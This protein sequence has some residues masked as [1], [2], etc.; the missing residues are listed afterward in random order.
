[1]GEAGT[2]AAQDVTGQV[3]SRALNPQVQYE[4]WQTLDAA[5]MGA[6]GGGGAYITLQA[7]PTKALDLIR[8]GQK[9][10]GNTTA[11]LRRVFPGAR[12]APDQVAAGKLIE[13]D[14]DL[15][16]FNEDPVQFGENLG[17][18]AADRARWAGAMI[19]KMVADKTIPSRIK[20]GLADLRGRLDDPEAQARVGS[21]WSAANAGRV[22]ARAV[23]AFEKAWG[24][25]K[26]V[27][28]GVAQGVKKSELGPEARFQEIL[29]IMNAGLR[30]DYQD[31]PQVLGLVRTVARRLS[32]TEGELTDSQLKA[33]GV[34]GRMFDDP[35][36]TYNQLLGAIGSENL[37]EKVTRA[38]PAEHDARIANSVLR[39][40]L[41]EEA[42]DY[43]D[44]DP[45]AAVQ[46]GQLIDRIVSRG[47]GR[48]GDWPAAIATLANLYGSE[49]AL[50]DVLSYYRE[51]RG[52]DP[53]RTEAIVD[54]EGE[55]LELDED[56]GGE[57]D[58]GDRLTE[59]ETESDVGY[60]FKQSGTQNEPFG[61]R[62]E[63]ARAREQ[64]GRGD[65]IT[66]L[67][68]AQEQGDDLEAAAQYVRERHA[69]RL[70]DRREQGAV[71]EM[72]KRWSAFARETDPEKKAA[73]KKRW[74]YSKALLEPK[75]MTRTE[76]MAGRQAVLEK[77]SA[78]EVLKQFF[79]V[80][81]T[82]IQRNEFDVSDRDLAKM[83]VLAKQSYKDKK[84]NDERKRTLFDLVT[85]DGRKIK[86]S[87]ESVWKTWAE[88][89][90]RADE[91]RFTQEGARVE[92]PKPFMA[93]MFMEALVGLRM[94]EDVEAVNWDDDLL[95]DRD[96]GLTWGE[97][98]ITGLQNPEVKEFEQRMH[99]RAW[100]IQS[101][102][103]AAVTPDISG[104]LEEGF[105]VRKWRRRADPT[106]G[107]PTMIDDD[108]RKFGPVWRKKDTG[109]VSIDEER[110]KLETRLAEEEGIIKPSDVREIE[111]QRKD[112]QFPP[113]VYKF[114]EEFD[115]ILSRAGIDLAEINRLRTEA[116]KAAARLVGNIAR[117][118]GVPTEQVLGHAYGGENTT[119]ALGRLVITLAA[120]EIFHKRGLDPMRTAMHEVGHVIV[121]AVA[122]I[123][124]M[125]VAAQM[126]NLA[127]TPRV[128][129]QVLASR[130]KRGLGTMYVA[131]SPEELF[132]E[133]FAAYMG[134][135]LQLKTKNPLLRVFEYIKELLGRVGQEEETL[136]A[137]FE[138]V[139]RGE[140]N[141]LNLSPKQTG[142]T[143]TR[144]QVGRFVVYGLPHIGAATL[145]HLEHVLRNR[146]P[147]LKG[148]DWDSTFGVLLDELRHFTPPGAVLGD[149]V[150]YA[151][152][153]VGQGI[154]GD[155]LR[156]ALAESF[157]PDQW[158]TYGWDSANAPLMAAEAPV[159]APKADRWDY[160]T[161]Y[162]TEQVFEA[163]GVT[164]ENPRGTYKASMLD[165]VKQV[166]EFLAGAALTAESVMRQR[167]E[168]NKKMV[169]AENAGDMDTLEALEVQS[170]RLSDLVD[171]FSGEIFH[172]SADIKVFLEE[173]GDY[174]QYTDS[175]IDAYMK[176]VNALRDTV[177]QNLP[178][179][180][181]YSL[182]A[183]QQHEKLSEEEQQKIRE[184]IQKV[185]GP[186]IKV[187]FEELAGGTAGEWT[188]TAGER[189]IK[190]SIDIG[191]HG[192]SVARHEALH[193]LFGMIDKSDATVRKAWEDVRQSLQSPFV[194]KQL[195]KLLS[196]HPKALEA[197]NTDPDELMAYA[198]QF[199]AEGQL[200]LGPTV[201]NWFT[202][203]RDFLYR[204]LGVVGSEQKVE[205]LLQAFEDGK[206]AEPS[207]VGAVMADMR[208]ETLKDKLARIAPPVVDLG[209]KVFTSNSDQL[210]AL[211]F[212]PLTDLADQFYK[213]A[214][215]EGGEGLPFIQSHHRERALWLNKMTRITSALSREDLST[216][217]QSL[218]YERQGN[219]TAGAIRA[220]LKDMH[221]YMVDRGVQKVVFAPA[222]KGEQEKV[223]YEPLGYVENYY[224][225]AWSP[226][227]IR[228]NKDAF[229]QLLML[230]GQLTRREATATYDALS[231]ERSS[232][233]I[234][235]AETDRHLGYTPYAKAVQD[236]RMKFITPQ[237]MSK[238]E[239]FLDTDVVNV[240]S[241]Y[242]VQA[243]HRAEYANRFGN[244][245]EKIND[246]LVA[247]QNGGA[248]SQELDRAAK[249]IRALEGTYKYDFS[250][251]LR[252]VFNTITTYENVVLLPFA[253]VNSLVDP[254]GIALR[255]GD[256]VEG[257]RALSEG[258]RG[259]GKA[260]VGAERS[261][262]ARRVAEDLGI[263]DNS[264]QLAVLGDVYAGPY[265]SRWLKNVN[266][267]FFRWNGMSI[268]NDRMR[269]AALAAGKRFI[270]R[271]AEGAARG[272]EKSQRYM[273]ELG[274][275]G[276]TLEKDQEPSL[277]DQNVKDALYKFID[278][279]VL[280]PNAA[281]RP[282]WGSDPMWSLVFHLKQ[283]AFSFQNTIIRRALHEGTYGN[284]LP[285]AMLAS[286]VPF[287]M[288]F[289]TLKSAMLGALP[290]DYGF[291]DALLR[292]MQQSG[293]LGVGNF[294]ADAMADAGIGAT[295][296]TSF[297]GPSVEHGVK[298]A[299]TLA[300][301]DRSSIEGA[302]L[303]SV[304]LSP[305]AK[306]LAR[307]GVEAPPG[308]SL[309]G[310]AF[311]GVLLRSVSPSPLAEVLAQ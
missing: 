291:G 90:S 246:A 68:M 154:T 283:F 13:G 107:R 258:F 24:K 299:K 262:P 74:E 123:Y 288:A 211:G 104:D 193:D 285:Y 207:A 229:I 295:P 276:Y 197:A 260:V 308:T 289:G 287:A 282:L 200:R 62:D 199:W 208:L 235:L 9:N 130:S 95:I 36:I 67:E 134:G 271:H 161:S 82:G 168:I 206:F 108:E 101:R 215:R 122:A 92:Q 180:T 181:R 139:K 97:A 274:L 53:T 133:A 270:V 86:L 58:V 303:R 165:T 141:A 212:K 21:A 109:V 142:A 191:G 43:F 44:T 34:L 250:P 128:F 41:N 182:E 147:K 126:V 118:L 26:A 119:D 31:N 218:I 12:G 73:A 187:L 49:E 306:A 66:A 266:E 111:A 116:L 85:K 189:L 248:T 29:E 121:S 60:Y 8:A 33:V 37:A 213:E 194:K 135:D 265:M 269:I 217:W 1:M 84:R 157:V 79:V 256:W 162:S 210:R 297:L 294:G 175:E 39:S 231:D 19:D 137:I 20:A 14:A 115:E 252:K 237:N 280:R 311:E 219:P 30:P 64:I 173:A 273:K 275:E 72:Q 81:D 249:L 88:K 272:D 42:Q 301:D 99:D 166:M 254:M 203:L 91:G 278:G 71:E 201:T 261:D 47:L 174:D 240:L 241:T 150:R 144:D 80:R 195:Q 233:Q 305:L 263:I 292:G 238:F 124:G 129:E 192:M 304:P 255:S 186:D 244:R 202:R 145:Q 198:Y 216:A 18:A 307:A 281:V 245:G 117:V 63:A 220:M 259:L 300:G 148:K 132:A 169:E 65:V 225:R 52:G 153:L 159:E 204:L 298:I 106:T 164:E 110:E 176:I 172:P 54:R 69:A 93:R 251:E 77:L 27:A 156:V 234:E 38:R 120:A 223:T 227:R 179:K 296:G 224:P 102:E 2:E 167:R 243:T 214:E 114:R 125:D 131:L 222:K 178:R 184:W 228:A 45:D 105:E 89:M 46:F 230:E 75:E 196:E 51:A 5:A 32:Q 163:M 98:K 247:A 185:R 87:A 177:V 127:Q 146:Y 83:R 25:T 56:E 257:W 155:R 149:I 290:P 23:T 57:L 302:L 277:D 279:A 78:Q 253:L 160:K 239:R 236:R 221:K 17:K 171:R 188:D 16:L 40:G 96:S 10:A 7:A 151:Q 103:P 113:R 138:A 35:V 242:I 267:K 112:E 100:Y 158:A 48:E 293:V 11:F 286:Y 28:K 226:A 284:M 6:I 170:Y 59:R 140:L 268:W 310:P 205:G 55:L 76:D 61:E 15:D 232:G 143:L 264:L 190:I 136:A 309:L 183:P 4:P 152:V 3:A 50:N 209:H 22:A 94:R 70:R